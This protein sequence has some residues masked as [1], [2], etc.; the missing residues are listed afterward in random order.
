MRRRTKFLV[1]SNMRSGSTWL[2]TTL[3][4]LP[5]VVTDYE[6]KW[7][8]NYEPHKIHY[9][10]SEDSPTVSNLLDSLDANMPLVG[11]KFVFDPVELSKSDYVNLRNKFS[12]DLRIIHIVRRYRD[13]FLSS[14][15]GFYH[16]LNEASPR[17]VSEHLMASFAGSSPG[18]VIKPA[19]PAHISPVACYEE[20]K[21]YL[22]GDVWGA[23]LREEGFSYL[24]VSYEHLGEHIPEIAKFIGSS[25]TPETVADLVERPVTLKL[26]EVP[27][28]EVIANITELDPLFEQFE[29]LRA[30]LLGGDISRE[31]GS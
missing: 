11:S 15:R 25:A 26:P 23:R 27:A 4:A 8:I 18:Q 10:L 29:R 13:I 19:E 6:I 9:V 7:K 17:R 14:R 12:R 24:L 31:Y 21:I 1:V 28:T 30:C 16:Q 22:D 20:L 5:D 3:G 2:A